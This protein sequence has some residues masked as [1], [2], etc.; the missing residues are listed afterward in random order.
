M[1]RREASQGTVDTYKCT[2]TCLRKIYFSP[3]SCTSHRDISLSSLSLSAFLSLQISSIIHRTKPRRAM[4]SACESC[5]ASPE[6]DKR[7]AGKHLDPV[8]RLITLIN[9]EAASSKTKAARIVD[10]P[11]CG[12]KPRDSYVERD[13]ETTFAGTEYA[14]CPS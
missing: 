3:S 7:A 13:A 6:G 2:R 11:G 1:W 5:S 4:T 8:P 9:P 14:E 10:L 12:L